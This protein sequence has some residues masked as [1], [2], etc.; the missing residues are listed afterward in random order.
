MAALV[1]GII[2]C[3]GIGVIALLVKIF[4]RKQSFSSVN[5]EK[6]SNDSLPDILTE[7]EYRNIP[8]N[9]YYDEFIK[10]IGGPK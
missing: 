9:I 8:G 4:N 5:T 6:E 10:Q 1:F 2:V 7:P 3:L